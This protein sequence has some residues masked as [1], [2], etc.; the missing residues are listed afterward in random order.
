LNHTP[1]RGAKE[2]NA[3]DDALMVDQGTRVEVE[4]HF[5]MGYLYSRIVKGL[6]PGS[7]PG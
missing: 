3:A 1:Q 6:H 7:V 5:T 4:N 2:G